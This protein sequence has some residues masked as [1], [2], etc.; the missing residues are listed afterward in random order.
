M[1]PAAVAASLLGRLG[2]KLADRKGNA[3]VFT[4]ASGLII[5]G[6]VLLSSFTEITPV[7]IAS[8]L[9]FGNVG[10]SLMQIAMSN[11]MSRTLPPDQTGAGMGLFSMTSFMA[12]GIGSVV[13]GLAADLSPAASWNPLYTGSA[14]TIFSNLY[15]L[16]AVLH[17]GILL[18]YRWKFNPVTSKDS[19]EP[20][21][22]KK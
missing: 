10:Q 21:I 15:L 17:A 3:F 13:Y 7:W 14:S 1:V 8:F 11:S 20:A 12:H 9:I 22:S 18:I 19:A 4:I 6:F 2:G 16:M 5:S